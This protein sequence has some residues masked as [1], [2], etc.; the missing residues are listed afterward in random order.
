MQLTRA[1]AT[2]TQEPVQFNP[3][4]QDRGFASMLQASSD[5][6]HGAKAA[7]STPQ[8]LD[9]EQRLQQHWSIPE[10]TQIFERPQ[11]VMLETERS[12]ERFE[13]RARQVAEQMQRY[14][15]Q[16]MVALRF[17]VGGLSTQTRQPFD[18]SD[19]YLNPLWNT[20]RQVFGWSRGNS[21]LIS[22][23][24]G[25]GVAHT[26]AKAVVD[27]E[28]A[29]GENRQSAFIAGELRQYVGNILRQGFNSY[30]FNP[31]AP[32]ALM[33]QGIDPVLSLTASS[34]GM[35][36]GLDLSVASAAE[37]RGVGQG[38][39][40]AGHISVE[41][42]S[43]MLHADQLYGDSVQRENRDWLDLFTQLS[44]DAALGGQARYWVSQTLQT[45]ER[46]SSD[47][48]TAQQG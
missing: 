32:A 18:L 21:R 48:D 33:T 8:V 43:L 22:A 45:L 3:L 46:I 2:I 28:R 39:F 30:G 15:I 17:G 4:V 31:V 25:L 19:S 42:Y 38:L 10:Y 35:A 41:Q 27:I 37:L 13:E 26:L 16:A 20:E 36:A 12:F 34:K 40:M 6:L 14:D 23:I 7:T 24:G 9:V 11:R 5:A 47:R 44:S 29:S 1:T